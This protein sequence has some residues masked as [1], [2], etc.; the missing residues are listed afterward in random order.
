MV[1]WKIIF[2]NQYF[3]VNAL[4]HLKQESILKR[5]EMIHTDQKTIACIKCESAFFDTDSSKIHERIH[6]GE[7]PY[8]CSKCGQGIKR[9]EHLKIRER[10]HTRN[11]LFA[12]NVKRG[13]ARAHICKHTKGPTQ[14]RNLIPVQNVTRNLTA[15]IT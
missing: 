6:F 1:H 15:M 10:A 12:L 5:H 14:L 3:S 7:K 2:C 8:T 9:S 13:L 4:L 11:H